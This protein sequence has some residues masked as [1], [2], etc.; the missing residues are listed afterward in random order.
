MTLV[1]LFLALMF[2]SPHL[3][4]AESSVGTGGSR[5]VEAKLIL[6]E[7][8][9]VLEI[10]YPRRTFFIPH[11]VRQGLYDLVVKAKIEFREDVPKSCEEIYSDGPIVVCKKLA[12]VVKPKA[13]DKLGYGSMIQ[14]I[15]RGFL[16]MQN[17]RVTP[18]EL[19]LEISMGV[20][21]GKTIEEADALTKRGQVVADDKYLRDA[22]K[23]LMLAIEAIRSMIT[24]K[25]IFAE[26]KQA[27]L[28]K[29]K[30]AGEEGFKQLVRQH[31][32]LRYA[33]ELFKQSI[34]SDR[35]VAD[36]MERMGYFNLSKFEEL[37]EKKDRL[38][39]VATTQTLHLPKDPKTIADTNPGDPDSILKLMASPHYDPEAETRVAVNIRKPGKQTLLLVNADMINTFRTQFTFFRLM[40][41]EFMPDMGKQDDDFQITIPLFRKI[42][43]PLTAMLQE[44]IKIQN[45][46]KGN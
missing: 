11:S 14:W 45:A 41:H 30:E 26:W 19:R 13:W 29:R 38:K 9:D 31:A 42:I 17:A 28:D 12:M 40:M 27:Y 3:A 2:A 15:M 4:H 32:I 37:F 8:L 36:M 23:A 7:A 18:T 39:L 21:G 6:L 25:K 16:E 44:S 10:N 1:K 22:E 46:Q 43:D 20:I 33:D 5:A 24:N 35:H 34:P